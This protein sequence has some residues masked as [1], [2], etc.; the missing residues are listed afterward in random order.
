MVEARISGRAASLSAAVTEAAVIL[1]RARFPLVA[2]LGSDVS[3]V[4][5]ALARHLRGAFDHMASASLLTDLAVLQRS[6]W[7]TVSPTEVSR[8][9]DVLLAIGVS[10]DWPDRFFGQRKQPDILRITP[11]AAA[12]SF[13]ILRALVNDVPATR[14]GK[15]AGKLKPAAAQLRAAI[16]GVAVWQPGSIDEP[17]VEMLMG[18]VRDLNRHTRFSSMAL[19]GESNGSGANLVSGWLTG[20][21]LRTSLA[22]A[23]PVHDPWTFSADRLVSSGEADVALWVSTFDQSL[24]DWMDSLPTV[25][26][27]AKGTTARNWPA[28]LIE[29]GTPGIDHDG[30]V[31]DGRTGALGLR[32]CVQGTG[33]PSAGDVLDQIHGALQKR[34]AAA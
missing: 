18:L 28:V 24:P 26:L 2:G 1:G 7:M 10:G 11:K 29:T 6:G 22:G 33:A 31:F 27:V 3:G 21:P 19:A 23:A 20:L 34:D 13:A 4:R 16:F 30:I 15:A 5:A 12:A 32:K 8:S 14:L 25:A 9:C 17:T